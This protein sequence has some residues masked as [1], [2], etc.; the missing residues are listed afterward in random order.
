MTWSG[1]GLGRHPVRAALSERTIE[2][3][4]IL[5]VLVLIAACYVLIVDW[6]VLVAGWR[7][8]VGNL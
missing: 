4:R 3:V 5:I 8:F 7:N 6:G 2:V 1:F